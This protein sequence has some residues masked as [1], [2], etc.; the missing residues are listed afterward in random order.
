MTD[1]DELDRLFKRG[2]PGADPELWE[3]HR[4]VLNDSLRSAY[5]EIAAELRALR[6]VEKAAATYIKASPCDPDVTQIQWDAWKVYDAALAALR[7]V[8]GE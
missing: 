2:Q 6:E 8:R 7:K 4:A 1:L 5:P 3:F